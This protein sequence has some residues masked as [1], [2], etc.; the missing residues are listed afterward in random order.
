M[1]ELKLEGIT[2]AYGQNTVFRDFCYTFEE[3][4]IY[5]LQG[6]SGSGKTTL[7]RLIAGLDKDFSGTVTGG[8]IDNSSFV[9]QEYRLF[10]RLTA[11]D[12]VAIISNDIEGARVEATSLLRRMHFSD[13]DMNLLPS[14][15]SGGMKQRVS[16]ARAFLKRSSLLLLDEPTKELDPELVGEV[17]EMI[18]EASRDRTV[19]IVSHAKDDIERLGAITVNINQTQ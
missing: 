17:L 9:F 13:D 19:I 7:L 11:K 16:I 8:G 10:P 1:A 15:L 4:K 18:K 2:K 5:A 3:N 6:P 14:E 12:N